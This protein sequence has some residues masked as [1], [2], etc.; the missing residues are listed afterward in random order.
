[1]LV[2]IAILTVSA[3]ITIYAI[4]LWVDASTATQARGDINGK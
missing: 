2:I 4:S 3:V 1:M